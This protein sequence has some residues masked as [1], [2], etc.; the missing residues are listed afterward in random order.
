MSAFYVTLLQPHC[1]DFISSFK[2]V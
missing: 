2:H 1:A